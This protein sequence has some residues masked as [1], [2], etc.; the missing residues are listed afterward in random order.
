MFHDDAGRPLGILFYTFQCGVCITDIIVR[1]LLAL[2]LP[3]SCDAG[4]G[5]IVLY[6]KCRALVRILAVTHGLGLAELQVNGI[7][8]PVFSPLQVGG[9]QVIGNGAVILGVCLKVFTAR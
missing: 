4:F 8:K 5:N 1:K 6:K 9:A 2:E 3:G 7:G